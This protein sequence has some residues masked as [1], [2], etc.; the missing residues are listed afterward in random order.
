MANIGVVGLGNWGTALAQHLARS[1]HRVIGWAR[2][3]EIVDGI[4]KTHHNPLALSEVELS[5]NLVPTGDL[6]LTASQDFVVLVVSS[7][8]LKSTISSLKLKPTSV[9]VSAVKGLDS[10]SLETP[11]QLATHLLP[12]GT[13]LACISGPSFARDVVADKPCSVVS[14]SKD[15]STAQAVAEIFSARSFRVYTSTD[16]LGVELGGVLKNVIALAAGV[17]DGLGLGD[18]ARTAVITRGLHEITRLAVAMGA[19][20][21]T[22]S[23]L[24]GLG[25][26]VMTASSDL[27]RNR[28]V[29]VRLGK[30]EKLDSILK[31]L[32]SVAEGVRT[33]EIVEKLSNR[34]QVQ[35][36]ISEHVLKLIR[37]SITPQQLI[38]GLISRPIKSEY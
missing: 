27:S 16:P 18:S 36:P 10:E 11:L 1:G 13:K 7:S 9:L 2:E 15:D 21:R 38:A 17:S 28:T 32:G 35:M 29:G 6:N 19:Q 37:G 3:P 4:T 24:S 33:A 5:P 22:L 23:G 20:E 34:Y 31:S 14:A 25:D 30:G 8:A 26:L 12:K